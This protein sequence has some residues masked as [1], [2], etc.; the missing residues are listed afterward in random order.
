MTSNFGKRASTVFRFSRIGRHGEAQVSITKSPGAV[1][2][3]ASSSSRAD[4]RGK[5]G[6]A[7]RAASASAAASVAP[8]G[9]SATVCVNTDD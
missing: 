7:S 1:R 2:A 4:P 3:M 9:G 8:E 5:E 6:A